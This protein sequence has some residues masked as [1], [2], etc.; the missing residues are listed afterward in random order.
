[1]PN[2][3]ERGRTRS[4]S[5]TPNPNKHVKPHPTD[6]TKVIVKDPHTGKSHERP[7]KDGDPPPATPP[8]AT[9]PPAT[10]PPKAPPAKSEVCDE[11][12]RD[13]A[14]DAVAVAGTAYIVYRCARMLPSLL[15]PLW[16]TIPANA[17]V[18]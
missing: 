13:T 16:W 1:E 8:P 11:Q 7:R 17:A 10:P 6:P 5:G 12:C 3:G 4:P 2:R 18:P 14:V 15:P 9:P